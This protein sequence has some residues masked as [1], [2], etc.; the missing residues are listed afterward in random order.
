MT[1]K[2]GYKG[3]VYIGA[4]KIG[5]TTTWNYSGSTRNMQAIDQFQDEVITH[6]PLQIEGGDI[7]IT[8]NYLMHEDAG[9]QLLRTNFE[10]GAEITDVK[11]YTSKA[12]NI[13]LTSD[14]ASTPSSY[15]T[16]VNYDNVGDDKSG[17][18]TFTCTLKVSGRLK[19][20]Y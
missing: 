18:G 11:L 15:V 6:L 19:P 1:V 17:V 4:V 12:D 9:Q 20:V 10:S 5:G 16:V 8:G 13:Y 14:G 3:A 7:T 2:A